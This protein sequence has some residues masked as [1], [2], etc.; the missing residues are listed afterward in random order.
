MRWIKSALSTDIGKQ[1]ENIALNFLIKNGLQLYK[2][3][4]HCRSGEIDIIMQDQL[5]WVFVEVKYRQNSHFGNAADYFHSSKRKK[6]TSALKH[7]MHHQRLN[8]AM[9]PHRIDLI[10]IEGEEIQWFKGV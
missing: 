2:K 5:E 1:A 9:V 8:P 10:A 6:F 4:Y 7:F 3:N